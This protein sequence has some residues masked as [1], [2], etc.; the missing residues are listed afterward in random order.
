[1]PLQDTDAWVS[2]RWVEGGGLEEF[3]DVAGGVLGQD[4]PAAWSLE[5]VVAKWGTR[6]AEA[7]GF[8]IDVVHYEVN[9]PLAGVLHLSG[10]GSESASPCRISTR[11]A[12]PVRLLS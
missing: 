3:D 9:A 6:G 11:S 2:S 5:D 4:L 1:M 7:G 8:G 10:A 12:S